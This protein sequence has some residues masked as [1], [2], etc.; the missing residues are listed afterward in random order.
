VKAV[1]SKNRKFLA[2]NLVFLLSL[3]CAWQWFNRP[4]KNQENL[5]TLV[6][7]NL[8]GWN[9]Q[10]IPVGETVER[11]LGT[12]KTLNGKYTNSKQERISVFVAEWPSTAHSGMESLGHTPDICWT[13]AGW[14]YSTVDYLPTPK[15]KI[16]GI[17]IL[18]TVRLFKSPIESRLELACWWT[19]I[20]G[21]VYEIDFPSQNQLAIRQHEK[22]FA[23]YLG[24]AK[25]G[26][27]FIHSIA[28][29]LKSNHQKQ[30]IRI[31]TEADS[32]LQLATERLSCFLGEWIKQ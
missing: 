8:G 5:I 22:S 16:N 26:K 13:A 30:I 29:R 15:I 17:E 25:W 21:Q 28:S 9:F 32:D 7:T 20:N 31:S 6:R 23:E 10:E 19:T 11:Q 3:Y 27:F 12:T 1:L 14:E 2:L 18:P 24:R 4:Q